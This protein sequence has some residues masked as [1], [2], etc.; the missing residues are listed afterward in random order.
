MAMFTEEELEELRRADAEIEESY[1]ISGADIAFSKMLDREAKLDRLDHKGKRIAE[2]NA[3][4][5]EANKDR[6][7]ERNAAYR[8]ANKDR[9]AERRRANREQR[10]AY[11][12]EYM[13]KRRA[14][15]KN[16]ASGGGAPESGKG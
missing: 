15:K 3:A 4:Y 2:R 10:N 7:A 1:S 12:R 5:Y 9:I 14:Q 13:R 6:I 16:A 11:M 8:E